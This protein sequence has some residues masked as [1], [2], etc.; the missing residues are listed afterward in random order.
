MKNL[1]KIN[2]KIIFKRNRNYYQCR[3]NQKVAMSLILM[4]KFNLEKKFLKVEN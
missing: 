3:S 4:Q 1:F 2:E